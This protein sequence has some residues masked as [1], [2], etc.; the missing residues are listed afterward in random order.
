[1][2]YS[3]PTERPAIG[4][5]LKFDHIKFHVGNAK[6]AASFYTSRFGFEFAAYQGH[7]FI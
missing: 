2:D 6:Q 4:K 1:M 7:A 3:K 5:F